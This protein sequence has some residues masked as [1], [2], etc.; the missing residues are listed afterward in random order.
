MRH[1][2]DDLIRYLCPGKPGE[3]LTGVMHLS[4]DNAVSQSV[5]Y[6]FKYV[7]SKYY[8]GDCSSCSEADE[9][10]EAFI[11]GASETEEEKKEMEEEFKY[12]LQQF[13]IEVRDG[14]GGWRVISMIGVT[15]LISF[16]GCAHDDDDDGGDDDEVLKELKFDYDDDANIDDD[17]N[18]MVMVMVLQL[19]TLT[20]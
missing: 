17:N 3:Y 7:L 6:P 13:K 11:E 10:Y 18:W 16:G 1:K 8:F 15:A 19:V 12:E 2:K 20:H 9:D 4:N 14:G 5:Q